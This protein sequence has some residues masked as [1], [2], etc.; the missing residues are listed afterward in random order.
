EGGGGEM[1]MLHGRVFEKM[2]VHIST[3]HGHF[4]ADF[5]RNMPGAEENAA[6]W[7]S[8]ISVIGHPRNPHVP[9]VHMNT[10]MIVTSKWWF[11]GGADLTPVLDWRRTQDD[12]IRATSMR[13][14][15]LPVPATPPPTTIATRP[16]AT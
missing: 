3:V 14:C 15:A 7:S 9:A 4:T 13:P 8:G 2:G 5:A 1:S 11:G 6:F 16:G 12:P 10:R